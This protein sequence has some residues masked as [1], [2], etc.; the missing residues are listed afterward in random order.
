MGDH[1]VGG[2]FSCAS[3]NNLRTLLDRYSLS[4]GAIILLGVNSLGPARASNRSVEVMK[5]VA[6]VGVHIAESGSGVVHRQLATHL[7]EALGPDWNVISSPIVEKASPL[8]VRFAKRIEQADVVISTGSPFPLRVRGLV[9]PLILD[10]RWAWT[11]STA[12]RLYRHIDLVRA[13]HRGQRILTISHTVAAQL[14]YVDRMR[15]PVDV[16]PLG[17][18]QFEGF[19]VSTPW[20]SQTLL[21]IGKSAHKNNEYAAKL[22]V[23]SP[24]VRDG[25]RVVAVNVSQQTKS[26]LSSSLDSERLVIVDRPKPDEL[27]KIYSRSSAYVS[28]GVSEGFGFPYIEATYFGADVIAPDHALVR[29]LLGFDG[30]FLMETELRVEA[31]EQAILQWDR[32]RILRM[33]RRSFARSWASTAT[34]AAKA[35]KAVYE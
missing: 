32:E 5:S 31:L 8:A 20:N 19:E 27:A 34:V 18:G 10:V 6:I 35:V 7:S 12:P 2:P 1:F 11:R 28:L 21:L 22:F 25:Y 26:I 16:L 13:L 29:E 3:P 30:N 9:I 17:P 33:Q 24:L 15:K 23:E 14:Q 4:H